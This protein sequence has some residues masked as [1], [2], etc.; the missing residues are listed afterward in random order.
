MSS[1]VDICNRALSKIGVQ[2]AIASLAEASNE[3]VQCALWYDNVRTSLLRT[4][5]WGFARRTLALTQLGDLADNTA[6]YPYLYKYAYPSDCVKLRYLL[7]PQAV[8][9]N[10][11]SPPQVGN[12]GNAGAWLMPSRENRFIVAADVDGMGVQSKVILSNVYQALGVYTMDVVNPDMFDDMFDGALSVALAAH[13]VM[14]LTGKVGLAETF[15][16]IAE[17]SILNARAADA[18]EAIPSVDHT[19][20]WITTRGVGSYGGPYA[21]WGNWFGGYD[22]MAWSS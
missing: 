15:A 21:T 11:I 12:P 22:S 3:A 8:A 13:L 7:A 20:D 10:S 18:N 17:Q 6:P 2:A 1:I 4:A 16:K 14:P 5:P 9:T 19:P